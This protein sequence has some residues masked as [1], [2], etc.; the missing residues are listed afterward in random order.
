MCTMI[1]SPTQVFDWI[2]RQERKKLLNRPEQFW[3]D[4]ASQNKID[5]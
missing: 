3:K 1:G 5:F 4:T 2:N